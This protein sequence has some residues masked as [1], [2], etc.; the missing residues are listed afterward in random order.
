MG[1]GSEEVEDLEEAVEALGKI[2]GLTNLLV[3]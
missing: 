2:V 1:E 3:Y